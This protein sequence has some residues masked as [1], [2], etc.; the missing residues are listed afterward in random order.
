MLRGLEAVLPRVGNF[1]YC[2]REGIHPP[3]VE[4]NAA[5][6]HFYHLSELLS[7]SFNPGWRR[8][9]KNANKNGSRNTR[10]ASNSNV[11]ANR[12]LEQQHASALAAMGRTALLAARPCEPIAS[13]L[14]QLAPN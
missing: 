7:F 13:D 4:G 11:Q 14:K 12:N 5:G 1:A 9:G 10:H 3:G 6:A 2:K 8:M